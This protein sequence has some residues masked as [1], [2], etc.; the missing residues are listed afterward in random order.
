[1]IAATDLIGGDFVQARMQ[2]TTTPGAPEQWLVTEFTVTT[3]TGTVVAGSVLYP[4][5]LDATAGWGF[6]LIA[7]TGLTL[8]TVLTEIN[9]TLIDGRA[10]MLMGRGLVWSDV[11]SGM[12]VAPASILSFTLV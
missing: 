4:T 11:D 8:P 7:R 12:P 10:L 6:E 5:G 1:M 9:A 2:G 3:V